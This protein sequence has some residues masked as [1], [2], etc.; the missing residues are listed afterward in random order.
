M[1]IVFYE[2]RPD[3]NGEFEAMSTWM[4]YTHSTVEIFVSLI[5]KR[6]VEGRTCYALAQ[7]E[8]SKSL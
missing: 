6:S 4:S 2:K 1:M 5:N 3:S 8:C 7:I